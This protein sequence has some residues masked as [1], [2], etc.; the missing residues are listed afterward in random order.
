MTAC[1]MKSVDGQVSRALRFDNRTCVIG[2]IQAC[3]LNDGNL[4]NMKKL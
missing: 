2:F 1:F 3:D 4:K